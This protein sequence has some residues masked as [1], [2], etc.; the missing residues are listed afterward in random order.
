MRTSVVVEVDWNVETENHPVNMTKQ[1]LLEHIV[2]SAQ[3]DANDF[4]LAAYIDGYVTAGMKQMEG[5]IRG[6]RKKD[7]SAIMHTFAQAAKNIFEKKYRL[8]PFK[9]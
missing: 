3:Y 5:A 9:P 7:I 4:A 6:M 2:G 1:E 8:T